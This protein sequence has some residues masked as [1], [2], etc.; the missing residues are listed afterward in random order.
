MEQDGRQV[1]GHFSYF[2][3]LPC[4]P[5]FMSSRLGWAIQRMFWKEFNLTACFDCFDDVFSSAN[6]SMSKL[7]N[8][9]V[10]GL[11]FLVVHRKIFLQLRR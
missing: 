11:V 6:G 4:T 2:L 7:S 9:N 1:G 3:E 10:V 8:F 5:V